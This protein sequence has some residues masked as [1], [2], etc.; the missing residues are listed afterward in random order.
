MT[1][2]GDELRTVIAKKAEQLHVEEFFLRRKREAAQRQADET[3]AA[4]VALVRDVF[5]PL[6]TEFCTVMETAG[7][8]CGGKVEETVSATD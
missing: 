5:R 3:E 7:V 1:A 4:A 6:L 8:L 2:F